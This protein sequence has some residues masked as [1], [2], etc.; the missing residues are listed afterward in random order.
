MKTLTE[1]I[2]WLNEDHEHF[3]IEALKAIPRQP[4]QNMEIG[5]IRLYLT[6]CFGDSIGD[7]TYRDVWII[8]DQHI[9]KLAKGSAT[10]EQNST[11]ILNAECVG[12]S[13]AI[14]VLDKHPDDFW[15]L[16]ER[17]TPLTEKE[18]VV[19]FGKKLGIKMGERTM[20]KSGIYTS[21][22]LLI[23]DVIEELVENKQS[24]RYE[25]I[26]PLFQKSLWVEGLIKALQGCNV[27]SQDLHWGNWGIRPS[28]GELVILDLGF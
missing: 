17:V 4:A 9:V 1:F 18:F 3:S 12:T 11:E 23:S 20:L 5:A 21:T 16:E 24:Y 27:S 10:V 13:Y 8:D 26:Y 25:G 15:L 28:S 22:S 19:A 2:V 7:G 6:K 14:R